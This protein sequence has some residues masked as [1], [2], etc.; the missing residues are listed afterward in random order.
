MFVKL[1]ARR[2]NGHLNFSL[3]LVTRLRFSKI[4]LCVGKLPK[5][6]WNVHS[7]R[8]INR[9]RALVYLFFAVLK[10]R[11]KTSNLMVVL[12]KDE[13]CHDQGYNES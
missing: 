5:L 7:S 10:W 1:N 13:N 8:L 3:I 6:S 4:T 11:R 12:E 2:F 9:V